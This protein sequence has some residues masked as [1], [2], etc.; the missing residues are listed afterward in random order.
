MFMG[1]DS[2]GYRV[3]PNRRT[4]A[5]L[6]L[7]GAAIITKF[8]YNQGANIKSAWLPSGR[9]GPVPDFLIKLLNLMGT[10]E[11]GPSFSMREWNELK[12][13]WRIMVP[14]AIGY[15]R[16][17]KFWTGKDPRF[18]I[19]LIAPLKYAPK[20]TWIKSY[21]N[22]SDEEAAEFVYMLKPDEVATLNKLAADIEAGREM[23][24]GRAERAAAAR[25]GLKF[26]DY[27]DKL[28][29]EKKKYDR[30][31][32]ELLKHDKI[33]EA[34]EM[35]TIEGYKGKNIDNKIVSLARQYCSSNQLLTLPAR[36]E[37]LHQGL[38]YGTIVMKKPTP[39][40]KPAGGSVALRP[41][42]P[43]DYEKLL[44][45][46]ND[47]EYYE[48]T[49]AKLTSGGGNV[50]AFEDAVEEARNYHEQ[51]IPNIKRRLP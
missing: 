43:A 46:V 16:F 19:L 35:L 13:S 39:T 5:Y 20:E 1:T 3:P 34:Y 51:T 25:I 38:R 8:L 28:R 37:E 12:N 26:R 17:H 29:E 11:R 30:S 44:L 15:N 40:E 45:F 21:E 50:K 49:R 4:G 48:E 27:A 14:Y 32:G 10:L 33:Q 2:Q 22:L 41:P 24:W 9:V 31:I 18:W 23:G 6:A 47:P 42:P 36:L 7:L